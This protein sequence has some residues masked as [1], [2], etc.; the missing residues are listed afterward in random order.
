[1][2][3]ICTIISCVQQF[4]LAVIC[5]VISCVQQIVWQSSVS[6]SSP[7]SVSNK[8]Y[9]SH[10]CHLLCP[11]DL[12][13]VI[14]IISC[15]QQI[16]WQS[17]VSS[18]PVFNNS[19]DDTRVLD[20][21]LEE[22]QHYAVAIQ[23]PLLLLQNLLTASKHPH[24]SL[25]SFCRSPLFRTK[26]PR[27]PLMSAS[28]SPSPAVRLMFIIFLKGPERRFTSEFQQDFRSSDHGSSANRRHLQ[29]R[30][31]E[32]ARLAKWDKGRKSRCDWAINWE[33][34]RRK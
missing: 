21:F 19:G 17:S 15:V 30:T 24:N 34:C 13:A 3:V 29:R 18:S 28:V 8:L 27:S 4:F 14:C 10:L 7:S 26:Y 9:G 12:M 2:A 1:M 16:V 31:Y 23:R 11:T 25:S 32:F 5:I 33:E 6:S 22:I 20:D